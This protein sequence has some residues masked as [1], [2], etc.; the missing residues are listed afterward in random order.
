MSR[1]AKG[2]GDDDGLVQRFQLLVWPDQSGTWSNVDRSPDLAARQEAYAVYERLDAIDP[3][4]IQAQF[5][6]GEDGLPY[7]RF[8]PEAQEI[9]NEWRTA[10]EARLRD[11]ELPPMLEGHLAKFRS[12]V[13]SL[14]L[15]IHL[16]DVGTGPVG[17]DSLIRACAWGEYLESHAR[18]VY[19]PAL[20]PDLVAARALADRIQSGRLGAEFAVRDVQQKGW[21]GLGDK[22]TIR[23]GLE[24]LEDLCWL[25][26]AREKTAGRPKTRC[27]VNPYVWKE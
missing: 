16:C 11:G 9:F 19:A 14:A 15:L 10:L 26:V 6:D 22:E 12:L 21:S 3:N 25:R 20:A 27:F 24:V 13:P 8:A 1:V 2:G 17:E 7:L 4:A 18:R 5:P 23:G